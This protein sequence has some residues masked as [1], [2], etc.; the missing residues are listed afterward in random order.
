MA[1]TQVVRSNNLVFSELT[2][3]TTF[4]VYRRPEKNALKTVEGSVDEDQEER[5]RGR[6]TWKSG[7]IYEGEFSDGRRNGVGRQMWRDGSVY[8]GDFV[9]DQRHG[10]GICSWSSGEVRGNF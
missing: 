8:E 7:E 10:E 1:E 6:F 5:E 9:N 4:E 3:S 2:A